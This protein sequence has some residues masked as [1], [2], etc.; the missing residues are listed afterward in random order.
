MTICMHLSL[1]LNHNPEDPEPH[2]TLWRVYI[3]HSGHWRITV[4]TWHTNTNLFIT[5]FFQAK[6]CQV[7]RE[8]ISW[9]YRLAWIRDRGGPNTCAYSSNS[10]IHWIELPN[11]IILSSNGISSI[12]RDVIWCSRKD[13]PNLVEHLPHRR[14]ST[15]TWWLDEQQETR[16]S[17]ISTSHINTAFTDIQDK[18]TFPIDFKYPW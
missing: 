16:H 12:N 11:H 1:H 7:L 15:S 4:H 2:M 17:L 14:C 9:P 10:N 13:S 5:H 6:G 3:T 18:V 8:T